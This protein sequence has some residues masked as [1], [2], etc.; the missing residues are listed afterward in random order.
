MLNMVKSSKLSADDE[1]PRLG[2]KGNYLR[3]SPEIVPRS[4]D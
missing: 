2:I 3:A 4:E 1:L